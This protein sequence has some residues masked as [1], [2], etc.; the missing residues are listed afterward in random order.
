M[1][2]ACHAA[3]Q[4]VQQRSELPSSQVV[5]Q[6]PHGGSQAHK[7]ERYGE[8][9]ERPQQPVLRSADSVAQQAQREPAGDGVGACEVGHGGHQAHERREERQRD[10]DP[11]RVPHNADGCH[12]PREAL[13][14]A[15]AAD[16]MLRKATSALGVHS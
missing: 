10:G 7:A 15:C 2:H 5:G 8:R 1:R 3:V 13:V 9:D 4:H 16:V 11:K 12:Q 6:R 14:I